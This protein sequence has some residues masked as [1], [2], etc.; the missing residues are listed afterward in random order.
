MMASQQTLD[1]RIA[2]LERQKKNAQRRLSYNR[3]KE[4]R[5]DFLTHNARLARN[6]YHDARAQVV[7]MLGGVCKTCGGLSDINI[8][9]KRGNGDACR[10]AHGGGYSH[11]RYHLK[12][13]CK[14][15]E[16]QC[17]LCHFEQHGGRWY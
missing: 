6:R 4:R 17:R 5:S 7:T 2:D 15:L 16:L 3:Q 10:K 14:G 12:N 11:L 13:N 8:H 1:D 9:H